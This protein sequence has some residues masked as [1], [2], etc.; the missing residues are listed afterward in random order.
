MI[1]NELVHVIYAPH[2]PQEK[3]KGTLVYLIGPIPGAEDWHKLAVAY[4]KHMAEE[5][6]IELTVACPQRLLQ[7]RENFTLDEK[8]KQMSWDIFFRNKAISDGL[9]LIWLPG[10]TKHICDHPYGQN[11]RF[12]LG[13]ICGLSRLLPLKFSV[14]ME[15][16]FPGA[17]NIE[18]ELRGMDIKIHNT[19]KETC[20][21]VINLV[22]TK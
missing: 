13:L 21:A 14:G 19:L 11:S 17:I 6:K 20:E 1:G 12:E 7:K 16:N 4:L 18:E 9:V 3:I 8:K 5:Q 22:K 2:I 15:N 10:E